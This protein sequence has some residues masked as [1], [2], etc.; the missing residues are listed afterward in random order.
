MLA[1]IL[2]VVRALLSR[3]AVASVGPVSVNQ[4]ACLSPQLEP[5]PVKN[6]ST[7]LFET[8]L[9]AYGA[10]RGT[11]RRSPST[12]SAGSTASTALT[13]TPRARI[14]WKQRRTKCEPTD[15]PPVPARDGPRRG[16]PRDE[17]VPLIQGCR[18]SDAGPEREQ[19]V[20]L[21]WLE[22]RLQHRVHGRG[23]RIDAHDIRTCS[24]LRSGHGGPCDSRSHG[25]GQ[26]RADGVD[27]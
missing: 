8:R 27:E 25:E 24:Y 26:G 16:G 13:P 5:Q 9:L 15:T 23:Y 4:V 12:G 10:E 2:P 14:R 21:F 11:Q 17:D 22:K 1:L 3:S 20:L 7:S 18:N 19:T 6:G